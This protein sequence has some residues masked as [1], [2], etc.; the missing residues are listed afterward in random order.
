MSTFTIDADNNITAYANAE[1]ANQGDAAGLIHFDSQATFAKLSA[2][3][4]L[5]RFVEI[6]N[7]IPGQTPVKEVPG[8]QESRRAGSGQRFNRWPARNSRRNPQP[9]SP[10]PRAKA[11]SRRRRPKPRKRRPASR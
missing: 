1:E 3:W 9:R 11:Q 4:P 2:D 5:S 7:G 8:P 6:W 10:S